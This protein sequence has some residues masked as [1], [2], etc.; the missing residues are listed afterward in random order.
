MEERTEDE[1][2]SEKETTSKKKVALSPDTYWLTRIVILRS[3][4]LIYVVAFLVALQQNKALIGSGGILPANHFLTRVKRYLGPSI[5]TLQLRLPSVLWFVNFENHL[6]FWLDAIATSGLLLSLTILL[7]GTANMIIMTSLWLLYQSLVNVGQSWYSFGWESQLMETGFLGIFLCPLFRLK[8][9]HSKDEGPSRFFIGSYR[10]LIFRIMIGAGLIKIRGDQCWR[11][12]TCMNY[13]Y[14]TQPV[15]NPVSPF[16][17]ASP[18]WFHKFEV[19]TNHVVELFMPFL[20]IPFLPRWCRNLCGISQVLFQMILIISGNLSFLNWLTIIPSLACFDDKFLSLMFSSETINK[21]RHLQSSDG[22]VLSK[23]L[24]L[25]IFRRVVDLMISLMIGYLSLPVVMNLVSSSQ[26][27]NTSFDPFRIVNTYGAF[28]SITKQRHELIIQGTDSSDP[29]TIDN[30]WKTY[31]F[32][33]KPG[34]PSRRPCL[35]S[36]YHYRLDWLM[37]FA[38]FQHPFQNEWLIKFGIKL[39]ENDPG[40]TSLIHYNPFLHSDIQD[41]APQSPKFLRIQFYEYKYCRIFGKEW[42]KGKW[43][44]RKKRQN[45]WPPMDIRLLT[46]RL[47]NMG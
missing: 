28:G 23:E 16:L 31:E 4:G 5:I 46:Q 41:V 39:L 38:A 44:C 7:S 37:W 24:N 2:S 36:P 20:L 40:V 34:D 43:W 18:E 29:Y 1:C 3:L 42:Q 9:L 8:H 14:L 13:H 45:Y 26:V 19:L 30:N 12:L 10:W 47:H 11:D 22:T 25:R 35:I 27:M 6:D 15:P 33:C 32:K 21:V 17:H